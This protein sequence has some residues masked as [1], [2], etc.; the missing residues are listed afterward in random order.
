MYKYHPLVSIVIPVYNGSNYLAQAIDSALNQTYDNVEVIVVNDGSTDNGL[1]DSVA[2]SFGNKI[3][4]YK[5][6][7]GGSSSAINEGIKHM[8]GEWFSWLS[9]DDM[10][11][12]EKVE[13]QINY[14]N[15]MLE[16]KKIKKEDIKKNVL[17]SAFELIDKDG[18]LIRRQ[19][20]N[21]INKI[22]NKINNR[23]SNSY[24]IAEPTKINFHGCSCLINKYIFE[25][26]GMFEENLRWLNDYDMWFRIYAA[27]FNICYVPEILVKGRIHSNQVSATIGFSY[28]N[29]EQ[30]MFW[31][32]SLRW[33]S[34]NEINNFE[35][36]YM[37]GKN[38][39]EKTRYVEGNKSFSIAENISPEFKI[40][41]KFV[42]LF[43]IVYS[44]CKEFL[45]KLYLKSQFKK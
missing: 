42:K 30:D 37:F 45:K 9:H 16:S 13:I 35:V 32:R 28:H 34:E 19:T 18:K 20:P 25:K 41:L 27:N 8:Q 38:A 4:Y 22:N 44:K 11:F 12:P 7:N 43:L 40:K 6:K 1:T 29:K 21:E 2:Y 10:Y 31:K 14:L 17:F 24:L 5:K 23:N 3:K 33:L 15:R 39:F 36:F 26:V